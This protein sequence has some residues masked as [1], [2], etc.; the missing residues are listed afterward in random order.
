MEHFDWIADERHALA[1]LLS[2]LTPAQLA[3][4]SLCGAWT[5]QQVFGHLT[6]PLTV[7]LPQFALAMLAARGNFDR[8]NDVLAR[9]A[10]AA[11]PTALARL[12]HDRA[13]SRFTP[14][15][16]DW[17]APLTDV[18]V[19]GQD[20]RRPLGLA[21]EF[22]P[23]RLRAILDYLVTDAAHR[24]FVPAGRLAGLALTASDLGWTW[25][26]GALV[27]GPAEALALVM[28]GRAAAL[29]DLQ[30]PGVETLRGSLVRARPCRRS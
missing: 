2:G 1:T 28:T 26:V 13:D 10:T 3:T 30:G 15:G 25:G 12:L 20:I 17:H 14:P 8:A 23:E 11:G 9:K 19:H 29:A 5:V 27:E 6:V 4:P 22:A 21:H 7:G 18:I 16:G 24:G